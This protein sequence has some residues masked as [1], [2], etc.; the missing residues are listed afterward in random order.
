MPQTMEVPYI[1]A[2]CGQTVAMVLLTD[3]QTPWDVFQQQLLD[4]KRTCKGGA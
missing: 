4:H 2:A 3:E 1:H